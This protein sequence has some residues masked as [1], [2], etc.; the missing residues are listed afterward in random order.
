MDSLVVD[1]MNVETNDYT[2]LIDVNSE[3]QICEA[4]D[5]TRVFVLE[6]DESRHLDLHDDGYPV[7]RDSLEHCCGWEVQ[8]VHICEENT[9]NT[10]V[11]DLEDYLDAREKP[12]FDEDF[13]TAPLKVAQ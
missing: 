10:Y 12:V 9:G 7:S 13:L 5:G 11:F 6:R 4:E 8:E 2:E 1:S 3:G